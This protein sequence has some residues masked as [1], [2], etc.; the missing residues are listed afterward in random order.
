LTAEDARL[1][2]EHGVDAIAVSNHGGRQL[3]G[4]IASLDALPEV[5]DAVAGRAEVWCDGGVRAGTEVLKALAIGARIVLVGRP[6]L[7]GLAAAGEEGVLRVLE[8]LR[9][10]IDHA[11][12][13]CGCRSPAELTRAHVVL[14]RGA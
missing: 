4:V 5:V 10:E 12:A 2:V 7:W 8:G 14:P 9:V 3:D 11:L 13:L 6:L 1:A